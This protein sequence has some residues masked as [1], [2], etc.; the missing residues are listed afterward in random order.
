MRTSPHR[1]LRIPLTFCLV[2]LLAVSTPGCSL[3]ADSKATLNVTASDP[4][5]QIW[6]DGALVGTGTAQAVV[7]RGEAHVVKAQLGERVAER[8][9]GRE[10]STTG[11]LDMIGGVLFLIPLLGLLAPGFWDLEEDHVSI[12]IPW[13]AA[14]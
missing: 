7:S 3:F 4:A 14:N 5:A 8:S 9:I 13:A 12:V 1:L 2:C 10:M 6:I 11:L